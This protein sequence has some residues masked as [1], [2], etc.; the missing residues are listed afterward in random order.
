MERIAPGRLHHLRDDNLG[1]PPEEVVECTAPRGLLSKDADA[2]PTDL[3]VRHL[4]QR[5]ARCDR[6]VAEKSLD[7]D[8]P[9]VADSGGF[10]RRAIRQERGN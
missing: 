9:F 6:I 4:Q 5:L 3:A 10:D 1:I 8:H 2:K 7:A